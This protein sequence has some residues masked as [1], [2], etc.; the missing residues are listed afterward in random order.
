MSNKNVLHLVFNAASTIQAGSW[1]T[2]NSP[3]FALF[4][5]KTD[6]AFASEIF[7]DQVVKSFV[8]LLVR[9]SWEQRK[10]VASKQTF[11]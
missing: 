6:C 2:N 10:D 8:C 9:R 1:R 5:I 11:Y 7:E 3:F 4:S